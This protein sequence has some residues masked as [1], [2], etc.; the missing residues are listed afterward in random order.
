[1][2][3]TLLVTVRFHDGRYHG[4]DSR[5]AGE[6]PP[7][8]ARLFQALMSG[9][10]RGATVPGEV[11]AALDWLE[12]LPPP[13]IA[14]PRGTPGQPFTTYVPNNDLDAELSK[15]KSPDIGKAVAA[16]RVGKR[17]RPILFDAGTPVLYC[18]TFGD[19]G[20]DGQAAALCAAAN[21]LYQLGRGVDMAWAEAVVMDS[22]EAEQRL[23]SHRGIVYRPSGNGTSDR[24]LLCPRPGLRRS[25]AARFEGVRTRFRTGGTNRKPIRLFVQ[26]PKPR[27]AK[28]AYDARPH[29][30]VF[31]LR[32]G[33]ARAAFSRRSLK[34]AAELVQEVRDKA[35]D[36]LRHALPDSADDVERYL[37][38]RDARDPDKAARVRIVPIPSVGSE[39]VDMAIRR[40]VVYVPQSCPLAADDLAW[41]FA[42]VAWWDADG[43]LLEELQR[44]DD[45]RMVSS[46]ERPGWRW[47]SVTPLALP[48]ARRR[49]IEPGRQTDEAKGAAERAVEEARAAG[50]VRQALRHAGTGVPA[51][52]VRVQREPFHHRGARAESFASGTRFTKD[53]LWHAE[54]TF[55]EPVAGP[56]LLGNGRFLGLGLMLPSEA[57]RGVLAFAITGGLANRADPIAVAHAARRAMMARVQR[58]LPRGERLPAYVSGHEEDGAPAGGGAHRHIAVAADLPRGR[59]LYIAPDRLQRRGTGWRELEKVHRQTAQALEGMDVLRAGAAGRLVLAPTVVDSES[60]PLFAPARIWESV[61]DYHVTRHHRRLSDEDALKTDIAAEL[62]RRGWPRVRP[63]SIEILAI[64]PG[65]RG[66]L[67]GRARLAFPTAQSGPLLIGRTSHKGGGLFAGARSRP[68]GASSLS[69]S[70]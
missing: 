64:R 54:V 34:G 50:A 21:G 61:T 56:L 43:V 52:R 36:R 62:E 19:S 1:M 26:P 29:R 65:P 6:W 24:E 53:V 51:A 8:P 12:T 59:L 3:H 32:A 47:R 67:A 41:A 70:R 35:A 25:L 39:H 28:V 17:F 48:L 55:A 31:E 45:D 60:D 63:D 15:G 40:L 58:R 44:V 37:I 46:F 23:S 11:R 33:G 13:V 22:D 69:V 4:L 10:A 20:G 5:K 38:G 49:R 18:W 7:A 68:G 66:G 57:M 2:E 42:Q 30:F 16:I 9:A 27:L 14:A